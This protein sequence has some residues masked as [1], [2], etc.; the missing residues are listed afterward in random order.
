MLP[1][2][3]KGAFIISGKFLS[4]KL[5]SFLNKNYYNYYYEKEQKCGILV[6]SNSIKLSGYD[7]IGW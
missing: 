2:I 6:Q 5:C 7:K 3:K 4:I 1:S